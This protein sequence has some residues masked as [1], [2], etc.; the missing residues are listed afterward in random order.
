MRSIN[1]IATLRI[2]TIFCVRFSNQQNAVYTRKQ[3]LNNSGNNRRVTSRN[4]FRTCR[5]CT[6]VNVSDNYAKVKCWKQIL[7]RI[8][9]STLS[10]ASWCCPKKHLAIEQKCKGC[11]LAH[12]VKCFLKW[13][14]SVD[15]WPVVILL[16]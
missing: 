1:D 9:N 14:C 10:K 5:A 13:S 6:T 3:V 8:L 16:H 12:A 2:T 11:T 4:L 7:V 15:T